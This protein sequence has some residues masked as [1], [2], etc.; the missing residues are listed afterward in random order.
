MN[1][2]D[3]SSEKE[4]EKRSLKS[5]GK[6]RHNRINGFLWLIMNRFFKNNFPE[7]T[8]KRLSSVACHLPYDHLFPGISSRSNEFNGRQR[9]IIIWL[10]VLKEFLEYSFWHFHNYNNTAQEHQ[11]WISFVSVGLLFLFVRLGT[12]FLP[13]GM[14]R[15]LWSRMPER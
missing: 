15:I 8:N 2:I 12:I 4:T 6:I 14:R 5:I 9:K 11:K 1:S 3:S 10:T 13:W 7:L